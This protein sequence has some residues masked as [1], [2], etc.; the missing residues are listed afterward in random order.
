MSN[1][2]ISNADKPIVRITETFMLRKINPKEIVKKYF[3][4]E[5]INR[6]LPKNKIKINTNFVKL[7]KQIGPDSSSEIYRFTDKS[8][9]AQTILTTNHTSY[10][11][12]MDKNRGKLVDS[13]LIRC[14][15][16]KRNNMSNPIGIPISMQI[17][18]HNNVIFALIDPCCDFGCAFSYLKRKTEG[19]RYYRGPLY[20]NAEQMLN[21]LYY[22]VH[23]TKHGKS[24]QEKPDPDLL[25][26]NGGPLTD[27]EF[28]SN[29]AK[30][31]PLPTVTIL[32]A[33]KQFLKL[34]ISKRK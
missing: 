15:Y 10:Q 23:P 18:K 13:P 29:S 5:Y 11:F 30:Y 33:K 8:N 20:M 31:F 24:I 6:G 2:K 16:C 27:E 26:S 19:N 28:D 21:C 9:N 25:R 1:L 17:D 4:G 32:P 34:N 22:R 12:E 14:R 3:K 7:G